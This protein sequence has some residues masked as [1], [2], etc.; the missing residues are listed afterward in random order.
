MELS[1]RILNL[2]DKARRI[3]DSL[4]TE[5][6]TKTGLVMPFLAA[7]GYEVFDPEQVIPEF[8]A[9]VGTKKNEKVDYA[10]KINNRICI[11]IECKKAGAPLDI[12][13]ASQLFRYFSTTDARI[14]LLTNGIEY[15]LFTD[16]DAPNRMDSKPFLEINLLDLDESLLPELSKLSKE[17]YD[18]ESLLN[19]AGDFKYL[20]SIKS[21]LNGFFKEPSEDF[22]RLVCKPIVD[23]A[24]T[25]SK[26]EQF[27]PLVKKACG[28]FLNEWMKDRLSTALNV[29]SLDPKP[30][31]EI[32]S[33]EQSS[34]EQESEV[35]TTGEEFEGFFIVKGLLR[36]KVDSKRIVMRDTQSYC[37]ILLDDNNRKPL[38]RLY[39]NRKQKYIGVFNEKREE[40][41][42]AISSLDEIYAHE[43]QIFKVLAFYLSE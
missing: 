38:C 25:T 5:E 14:A 13:H 33:S 30:Q 36:K 22:V 4:Q 31:A 8:V 17:S 10:I 43:D 3:K 18:E 11:L 41:K 42:I 24:F 19:T 2:A 34:T 29:G 37:G 26:K 16:L 40:T 21:T 20:R 7:L 9:D 27:T 15:K 6:A 1:T 32:Q 39:F 35:V 28:Q 23:G 12:N